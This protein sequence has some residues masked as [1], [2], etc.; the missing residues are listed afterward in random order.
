M[1]VTEIA[2]EHGVS[3]QTVHTHR[4]RGAFPKPVEG[5]GSTRPRWREG[6]VAD[7]FAKNPPTP[8]KRTDLP[9]KQQGDTAVSEQQT[10]SLTREDVEACEQLH[11]T[12]DLIE[13]RW[14]GTHPTLVRDLRDLVDTI[15]EEAG[16]TDG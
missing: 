13:A 15:S 16:A 14:P 10:S 3:R 5:E 12:A 1:T 11:A 2:A 4:K 7:F 9:A 8:G 6:D